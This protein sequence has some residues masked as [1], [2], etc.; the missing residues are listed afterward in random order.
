ME[1][2]AFRSWAPLLWNKLYIFVQKADTT[3]DF[4]VKVWVSY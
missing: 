2:K 4:I 3:L 1:G